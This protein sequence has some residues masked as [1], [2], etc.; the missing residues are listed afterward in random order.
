MAEDGWAD[1]G[2]GTRRLGLA[3]WPRC[4]TPACKH[5]VMEHDNPTD[6]ERFATRS[7]HALRS[8]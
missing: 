5:F 1:V 3:A 4:A 8:L 2:H 7:L 6:H